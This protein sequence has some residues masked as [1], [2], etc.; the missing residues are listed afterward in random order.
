MVVEGLVAGEF[1]VG[2]GIRQQVEAASAANASLR[3]LP[4]RFM[5]IQQAMGTPASRG[6]EAG[7]YLSAFVEEMKASG[8]VAEAME[9]HGIQGAIVAPAANAG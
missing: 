6:G 3:V 1:E 5:V 4:G 7:A 9:R 8:F 2:A